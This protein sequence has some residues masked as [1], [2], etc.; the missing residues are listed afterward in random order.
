MAGPPVPSF[1]IY[2]SVRD[3]DGG[4]LAS[5][6]AYLSVLN[7]AG[8]EITRAPCDPS[9]GTGINY[10][11]AI[12][13]DSG[14]DTERYKP[15]SLRTGE[16]FSV[17]VLMDNESLVPSAAGVTSF[18]VGSPGTAT[19]YDLTLGEDTYKDGI[20]DDWKRAY[21][22]DNPQFTDISQITAGG[23]P[24][25]D[26][27]TNFQEFIAGTNPFDP[28]SLL[29]IEI[30]N[31]ENGYAELRFPAERGRTYLFMSSVNLRDWA[32]Q[33]VALKPGDQNLSGVLLSTDS[34]TLSVYAPQVYGTRALFYRMH[35]E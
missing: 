24:D 8:V 13:M 25:G 29:E 3:V 14:I 5:G 10:E 6:E 20:P 7:S 11:L 16:A 15:T 19:R 21:L 2:G 18:A 35:V 9:I 30:I 33:R 28:A 23:D 26:R 4:P 22:I 27:L 1:S 12:P 31:V 34:E 32:V 17:R